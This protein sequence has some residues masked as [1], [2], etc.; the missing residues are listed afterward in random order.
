MATVPE[1]DTTSVPA[2]HANGRRFRAIER[3]MLLDALGPAAMLTAG[4]LLGGALVSTIIDPV[5]GDTVLILNSL[6]AAITI[7]VVLV[8]RLGA[9]RRNA[10]LVCAAWSVL[11]VVDLFLAGLT[12]PLQCTLAITLMPLLP[13]L[14]AVFMP[15]QPWVQI[16]V[17]GA[18]SVAIGGLLMTLAQRA[19]EG[20][21]VGA[22][23]A[24][25][26]GSLLSIPGSL[27]LRRRRSDYVAQM[28]RARHLHRV[29]V[30][31]GRALS[32]LYR[33][34]AE[35][36]RV[37][38]LTGV[39]NRRRMAEELQR[40]ATSPTGA[41][42]LLLIDVDH[43]KRYNDAHGHLAGDRALRTIAD[44]LA[45]SVRAGDAVFRYGGEEFL[46]VLA[47]ADA[48]RAREVAERLRRSV[49][50]LSLTLD[51]G[52]GRASLS[53]SV[54]AAVNR[55]ARDP[56]LARALAAADAALYEAKRGGRNR[57]EIS[58][59]RALPASV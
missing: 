12:S 56:T 41:T 44:T 27:W 5:G 45:A 48:R 52:S 46:V 32:L 55:Y 2:F 19:P 36:A 10:E 54:G 58:T 13:L 50:D 1:R 8:S 39:G 7:A 26:V 57:V 17:A 20:V 15:V 40:R 25:L 42:A 51:A 21:V 30:E 3:R 23:M 29:A 6:S 49:A 34:Q 28:L 22:S 33:E 53:I 43:F 59:P 37:D 24:I 18:A 31:Q 35:S 9:G 4:A 14:F 16:I 38:P 47:D 11:L